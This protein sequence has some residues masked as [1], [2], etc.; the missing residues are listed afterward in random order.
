MRFLKLIKEEFQFILNS[1]GSMIVF[2]IGP[3]FLTLWLGTAYYNERIEK[4]PVAVLDEDNSEMSRKIIQYFDNSETFHVAQYAENRNELE[5]LVDSGDAKLALIIPIGLNTDILSGNQAHVEVF[6]DGTNIIIGNTAYSSAATILQTVSAGIGINVLGAKHSLTAD[7]AKNMALAFNIQERIPY[8]PKITYMNYLIYG[9]IAVFYQ[10]LFISG[11]A[12]LILRD[13]EEVSQNKKEL[14]VKFM[15]KVITAIVCAVAAFALPIYTIH[16]LYGVSLYKENIGF[17]ILFTIL[18]SFALSVPCILLC[19]FAKKK[20]KVSQISYML[21]LP[22]FL[23]CGYVWPESQM[24][25]ALAAIIKLLWPL[26]NF[27]RPF[28]EILI[29]GTSPLIFMPQIMGLILYALILI[30]ISLYLFH[31]KYEKNTNTVEIPV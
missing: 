29:K 28:D 14:P 10:Q 20:V 5:A 19:A 12:N 21:S 27:A 6:L 30:P 7:D 18:F 24:P 2:F 13:A 23:T 22:T 15:A 4:L 16:N 26:M 17:A 25:S 9:F 1:K 11:L 31:T 8:D 3:I